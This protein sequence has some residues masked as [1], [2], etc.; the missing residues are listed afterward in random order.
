MPRLRATWP[1]TTTL[2]SH[3]DESVDSRGTTPLGP[4][5]GG[6]LTPGGADRHDQVPR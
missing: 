5:I 3:R 6:P 4:N 1:L 2:S